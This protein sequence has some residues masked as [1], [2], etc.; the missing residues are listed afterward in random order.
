MRNS[1]CGCARCGAC[2]SA[3]RSVLNDDDALARKSSRGELTLLTGAKND[4]ILPVRRQKL[5]QCSS[6]MRQRPGQPDAAAAL[7]TLSSAIAAS[8]AEA[9]S[10]SVC[11]SSRR[12]C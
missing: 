6:Y 12:R 2:G 9:F 3:A 4:N 8:H 10:T 7:S 1:R 11:A 5:R